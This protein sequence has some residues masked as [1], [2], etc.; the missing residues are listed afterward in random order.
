[1]IGAIREHDREQKIGL[2]KETTALWEAVPLS[3]GSNDPQCCNCVTGWSI[4]EATRKK[5]KRD[6]RSKKPKGH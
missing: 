3:N 5:T 1:M 4:G 2:C 6:A